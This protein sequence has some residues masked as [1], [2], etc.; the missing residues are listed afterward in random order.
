MNNNELKNWIVSELRSQ[1]AIM[2]GYAN[3]PNS[4]G[5]THTN[6]KC[7]ILLWLVLGLLVF[8]QSALLVLSTAML[9]QRIDCIEKTLQLLQE[10]LPASST[11]SHFESY[12]IECDEACQDA[13]DIQKE[14]CLRQIP[15][16]LSEIHRYPDFSVRFCVQDYRIDTVQQAESIRFLFYAQYHSERK[17]NRQVC[18]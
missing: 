10:P 11:K 4:T 5:S 17:V 15:F 3:S 16:L 13:T 14:Q 8:A 6:L 12:Q 7:S 18:T 9:R 1:R 2:Y